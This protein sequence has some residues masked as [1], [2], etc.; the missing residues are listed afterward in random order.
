M[1]KYSNQELKTTL[2]NTL[3]V[4]DIKVRELDLK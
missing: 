3:A 1:V 4:Q 2:L